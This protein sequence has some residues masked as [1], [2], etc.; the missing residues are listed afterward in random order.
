MKYFYGD[1]QGT[2]TIGFSIKNSNND[3]GRLRRIEVE[4]I[5][6]PE[7]TFLERNYIRNNT[8]ID[9]EKLADQTGIK[10]IDVQKFLESI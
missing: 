7:L 2:F 8:M 10:E 4:S 1:I 5:D 6:T 9:K 3:K